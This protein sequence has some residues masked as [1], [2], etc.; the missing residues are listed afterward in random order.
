[1][2]TCN[3]AGLNLNVPLV[4]KPSTISTIS[5]SITTVHAPMM[6]FILSVKTNQTDGAVQRIHNTGMI[7][8]F[9]AGEFK[10]VVKAKDSWQLTVD[11][12]LRLLTRSKFHYY[13]DP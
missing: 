13:N 4:S 10:K 3:I 12:S 5:L 2:V 11:R 6:L 9:K 1:M 8:I 7:T